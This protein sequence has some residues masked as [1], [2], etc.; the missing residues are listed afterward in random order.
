M[1]SQTSLLARLKKAEWVIPQIKPSF[2]SALTKQ[3]K[4]ADE[5]SCDDLPLYVLTAFRYG[6]LDRHVTEFNSPAVVQRLLAAV[7]PS[8]QLIDS[9]F[10]TTPLAQE[11]LAR[12]AALD[13]NLADLYEQ[14]M[15]RLVQVDGGDFGAASS[16]KIFGLS[17]LTRAYSDLEPRRRLLSMVH[18]LAHHE[19]FLLNLVD[20]LVRPEYENSSAYAPFQGRERPPIGRLHAA[21]ALF[22]MRQL[23]RFAGWPTDEFDDEYAGTLASF[24]QAPELTEFATSLVCDVYRQM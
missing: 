19:L 23:A 22:R 13:H 10:H 18:E 3:L 15:E 20:R 4:F 7:G 1:S 9:D 14:T 21:H 16:P 11:D 24:A 12:L 2:R 5:G 17:V 6:L 8:M